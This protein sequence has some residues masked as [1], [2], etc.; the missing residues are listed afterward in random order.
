ME[1]VLQW[2][3]IARFLKIEHTLFSV[4]LIFAGVFLALREVPSV[5]LVILVLTAAVGARTVALSLNRIIDR[6]IDA[7]NPR[8]AN[9]ELPSKTMTL[10]E[11]ITVVGAGL[12]LYLVSAAFISTFCLILSPIPL[13]I[14]TL[15]P[16][17][18]RWTPL[19]HFGV[20][21]GLAMAP[22]GGW[23][24]VTGSFDGMLP[25]VLLGLFM[26]FW[27]SGFDI[28]YATLDEEFDRRENLYSLVATYGRRRALQ[29][30]ALLHIL[31][32]GVLVILWYIAQRG[33]IAFLFL[34]FSGYLLYLEHKKVDDVELAFFTINAVNGFVV[35]GMVIAGIYLP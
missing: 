21:A 28:I 5:R 19:A 11:A 29:I 17:L 26:F 32:F 14:F 15:Y 6:H 33:T 20:G 13:L 25:G 2:K 4:P 34:L 30:S 35:F 16:Y 23:F 27:A 10:P 22:L 8:T 12:V 9:R 1:H 18:K 31:S 24:A 3:K 7:R